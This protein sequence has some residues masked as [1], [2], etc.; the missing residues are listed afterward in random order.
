MN[1]FV[2]EIGR[3]VDMYGLVH[4]DRVGGERHRMM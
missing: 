3:M 1:E 4:L 2:C